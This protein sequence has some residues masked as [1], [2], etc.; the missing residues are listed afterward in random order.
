MKRS[1]R[2]ITPE[3]KRTAVGVMGVAATVLLHS[4]LFAVAI[5]GEG[6]H[7]ARLPDAVGAGANS[8]KMDGD[9]T[10]RMI[11]IR[12]SP[13]IANPEPEPTLAPQ[14]TTTPKVSMLEITGPDAIAP[15]PLEFDD[16]GEVTEASEAELIA[17]TKMAGMYESQIRARIERAWTA[18]KAE[19]YAPPYSCRVRI[20]QRRDGQIE[21]VKLEYCEGSLPWT[22]SL[23][24]AIYSASPLPGAPHPSVF[25]AS[26]SLTFRSVPAQADR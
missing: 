17:R 5:W 21:D 6:T 1:I 10:E 11:I 18:P 23:V 3:A 14:L 24:N 16:E 15:P 22:D 8:G 13:E 2:S 7:I 4:L 20:W 26:F 19:P 9:S 12:L 25:V